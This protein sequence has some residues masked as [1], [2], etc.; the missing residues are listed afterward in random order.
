MTL[1][2]IRA[3]YAEAT[4]PR[5]EPD[6]PDAIRARQAAWHRLR[7]EAERIVG[8]LLASG[9]WW[10]DQAELYAGQCANLRAELGK[11]NNA[12]RKA[13][14]REA[15]LRSEVDYQRARYEAEA[16]EHMATERV[17]WT[18]MIAHG[19]GCEACETARALLDDAQKGPTR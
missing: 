14:E 2:D 12:V 17:L 16:R 19:C 3:L 7:D 4:A 5:P 1:D 8:A 13:G 9:V 10:R 11:I 6:T 15:V 18:V